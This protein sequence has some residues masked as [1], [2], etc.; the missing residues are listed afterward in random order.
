MP[1]KQIRLALDDAVDEAEDARLHPDGDQSDDEVENPEGTSA[2][3]ARQIGRIEDLAENPDRLRAALQRNPY[4]ILERRDDAELEALGRRRMRAMATAAASTG[5]GQLL[6][7]TGVPAISHLPAAANAAHTVEQARSLY[8]IAAGFVEHNEEDHRLKATIENCAHERAGRSGG[9]WMSVAVGLGAA[10]AA[11]GAAA[12]IAA[13][14][15]GIAA[16]PAA[17]ISVGIGL[18]GM[19]AGKGADKGVNK[20]WNLGRVVNRR[21]AAETLIDNSIRPD[22]GPA[23]QA[24]RA[25]LQAMGLNLARLDGIAPT[26]PDAEETEARRALNETVR[27]LL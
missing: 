23:R 1:K 16:V 25:A 19:A 2:R 12:F 15:G 10:G 9:Q 17:A 24:A 22:D 5:A 7:R 27:G 14:T 8:Q 4:Q 20:L 21:Q 13:A 26:P 3:I 11:V 18:G 6:G